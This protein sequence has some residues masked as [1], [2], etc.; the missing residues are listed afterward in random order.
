ME[1]VVLRFVGVE[2]CRFTVGLLGSKMVS[3]GFV[4]SRVVISRVVISRAVSSMVVNRMG[5]SWVVI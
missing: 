3:S 1:V 2:G 4:S 5:S